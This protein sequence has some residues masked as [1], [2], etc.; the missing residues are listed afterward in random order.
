MIHIAG[1]VRTPPPAH[2]DQQAA[3]SHPHAAGPGHHQVQV[4]HDRRSGDDRGVRGAGRVAGVPAGRPQRRTVRGARQTLPGHGLLRAGRRRRHDSRA[5]AGRCRRR[6]HAEPV[7]RSRR[8]HAPHRRRGRSGRRRALSADLDAR[9]VCAPQACTRTTDIFTK[10]T[11]PLAHAG[12]ATRPSSSVAA[13][14]ETTSRRPDCAVPSVVAGGTPTFPIHAQ[15]AGRR[16]Q[17][18]HVASSGIWATARSCR[19]SISC[20]PCSC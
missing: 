5:V 8:R 2:E 9:R 12:C 13:R 11:S 3:R 14:C 1:G 19:T 17:S 10:P 7:P 4:R 6:R 20:R 16:V 15:A 18:R